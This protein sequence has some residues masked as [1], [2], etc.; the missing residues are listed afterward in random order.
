MARLYTV[1]FFS[2]AT[3]LIWETIWGR[4]LHLVFGTSQ[5]AIATVLCAFMAGLALGGAVAAKVADRIRNPVYVY[6][7]LEVFIGLYALAFPTLLSWIEPLYLSFWQQYQPGPI[8]FGLVQMVMVGVLLLLPTACMGATLPV[9]TPVVAHA[10]GGVGSAV[11]RL[12]AINTA[13]AVAGVWAGGFFLLP[14]YGIEQTAVGTMLANLV[15]GA[16]SLGIG[17]TTAQTPA[18]TGRVRVLPVA[19]GVAACA[20]C[21]SLMMEMAWFRLLTLV[22]GAS[23][24]AFTIMLLAFLVGIAVGGEAGGG[25]ADRLAKRG[26]LALGIALAQ[27]G[28]V[29]LTGGATWMYQWLPILFV[30]SWFAIKGVPELIWPMKCFI[31]M[32]VMTPPALLMGATFPM[33][34]RF[35]DPE[36]RSE[37]VG[38]LYAAN[39]AGSVVGAFLGGFVLLPTIAV[40]GTV[41]TALTINLIGAAWIGRQRREVPVVAALA[42]AFFWLNPPPWDPMLMTSGV[43]KYVDNMDTDTQ[44]ELEDQII[45]KYRL[46][47]YNEGLSTVITV[48]ENRTSSNRWL[49]NNGKIDASTTGD[50]PTQ[51]LV[52][53]LPFLFAENPEDVMLIGLA[54]G[55]TLGALTLHP[56]PQQISVV[57]IEPSMPTAARLFRYWN[58][59][60]LNDPRVQIYGNDGRNQLLLTPP[61]SCDIIV[62]EPSNPW[63]TGVANLFTRDFFEMGKQRLKPGGIWS[64]WV[65]MY[66]MDQ[67]DLYS[68]MRTFADAFPYVLVFATIEDA[69]LVMIGSDRPLS[70][71]E[72]A[73]KGLVDRNVG[74]ESELL[75]IGVEDVYDLLS[76]YLFDRERILSLTEGIPLNTDDNLLVE[77]SAPRNLHRHTSYKNMLSLV[78][79]AQVPTLQTA[80]GYIG[81][82]RSYRDRDNRARALMSLERADA[83]DPA[84]PDTL[85]LRLQYQRELLREAKE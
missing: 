52:A 84:R 73:A 3:S 12:Y 41:L 83:L 53:H 9:L 57:E 5:F 42:I 77:Y 7:A 59:D 68:V 13:G 10:T 36:G 61:Q 24:Y 64:Q 38:T 63:L 60:A 34:V 31:A 2:G 85:E 78:S 22:L 44:E 62:A 49:A 27:M 37:S 17:R 33:I 80:D 67:R 40:T 11:G 35:V 75:A 51:V 29:A 26:Q 30:K 79:Q 58:H 48:A 56:E 66:G 54:S 74:L 50:M 15:L 43:Y 70:V 16:L 4:E 55:I 69:D 25:I 72:A 8:L 46:L 81:L 65:Q 20:G 21:A 6:A 18:P 32:L 14:N 1:F 82:A 45:N 71:T 47:F 19:I 28:V 39:T 76:I 23:V